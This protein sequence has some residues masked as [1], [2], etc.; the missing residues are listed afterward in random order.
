MKHYICTRVTIVIGS[1]LV[2]L[3]Q[4]FKVEAAIIKGPYLQHV[5]RHSTVIMWETD[6]PTHS[7]VEFGSSGIRVQTDSYSPTTIHEIHITDLEPHTEY[8][9]RVSITGSADSWSKW[10]T[11][12]T[13]PGRDDTFRLVVYGDTRSHPDV[14]AQV[15]RGIIKSQPDLVVHTGDLVMSGRQYE[16]W[17][18]EFFTPARELLQSVP[19]FTVIGNH[20]GVGN[21]E[22]GPGLWYFDFLSLPGNE[23][24]YAFDYG[25]ARFVVLNTSGDFLPGSEQYQWLVNE[26]NSDEFKA[27]RWRFVGFHYP[28]FTS[29]SKHAAYLDVSEYIV[30]LLEQH[31]VFMVL[32][33]HNHN[34]E[35]SYKNG[36]HYVVSGGGGAGLSGFHQD[37]YPWNP[38]YVARAGEHH[39]C[40]LDISPDK[41][42]YKVL[43]NDSTIID[44]FDSTD[45][46]A[47]WVT[48]SF[49]EGDSE[50][51]DVPAEIEFH[52]DAH[53]PDGS[54]R[55][56]TFYNGQT[57][58]GSAERE[59]YTMTWENVPQGKYTL[60]ARASD[61]NDQSGASNVVSVVVGQFG[62]IRHTDAALVVDGR[63]DELW[64][65]VDP[66]AVENVVGNLPDNEDFSGEFR[67]LWDHQYLYM[68][69]TVRDDIK[70]LDSPERHFWDDG[71]GFFFDPNN[72]KSPAVTEDDLSFDYI[73]D[74]KEIQELKRGKTTGIDFAQLDTDDCYQLEIKFPWTLLGITPKQGHRIGFELHLIDDDDG[75]WRESKLI[76][77][78]KSDEENPK[79]FGRLKLVP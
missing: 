5:T 24:W 55:K 11:F 9:Y 66:Y 63:M 61:N 8:P 49:P 60:L 42:N 31:G 77:W 51:P 10:S 50:F 3:F 48:L 7:L 28:P 34:Y 17:E 30:P 78:G 36:I 58:L 70:A 54:I 37:P 13:A 35:R 76:W 4:I 23:R 65:T 62:E 45:N 32:A 69:V 41:V 21:Q 20:E 56:V 52:V 79:R 73:R 25:C 74:A 18:R 12:R 64:Q 67:A 75:H 19:M 15:V 2:S 29:A 39:H 68:L 22:P 14:H 26:L 71:I 33:G 59:P 6:V 44:G 46:M 53:D 16:D 57:E 1:A 40:V 47:P 38:Y 27:A 43:N 72:D